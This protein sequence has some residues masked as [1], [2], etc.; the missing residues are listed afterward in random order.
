MQNRFGFK[1]GVLL[2]L[3]LIVGV[4]VVVGMYG[5]DR[6]FSKLQAVDA[7]I[8]ELEGAVASQQQGSSSA[9]VSE[10]RAELNAIRDAIA[11]RPIN[12]NMSGMGVSG[13]PT[14][15]TSTTDAETES[16]T[17][18][19][20]TTAPADS[21]SA[22]K[23]GWARPGVEIAWQEPWSF[24]TNP[25]DIPGFEQGGEFTEIIGAQPPRITPYLSSDVYGRR[26]IDQVMQSLGAYDSET[27]ETRGVLA[28][29]WQFD[30]DGLWLRVHINPDARFSD[31]V[32]VTAEDV[33]YT[34]MDFIK[35]ERIEAERSR[36]TLE[37]IQDVEII[38]EHTVEF[39][40]DKA[41]F[42]N[43][44]YTLGIYVLPKHFYS[45]L[46]ESTINQSTGLIMG[47]GPFRLEIINPDD[48]W[49][50]GED[51]QIVRNER[52]WGA[53]KAPLASMRFKV[54]KE[55]TA[56]LVG[57]RNGDGDML[58]PSSTQYDKLRSDTDFLADNAIYKWV[59]MRSGYSFIGW[60]CGRRGGSADGPW[61]PFH[62]MRV[63]RAMTMTLNREDM[64]RDIWAGVGVVSTGPNSPSSPS[65]NPAITPWPYDLDGARA[66]LKE[67]GWEDADGDGILEYQKDDEYF[68]KGTPFK[69]EFTI[70]NSGETSERIISYLVSQCEEVGITCVPRVVDWSFYSD[71]LKRRDF[72]A[73]IM[74]WSASS[75]ESDPRQIWHR[76]SIQDQG[77]NFI[78]WDSQ[79]ASDLVDKGRTSMDRDERMLVWHDFHSVVHEEQPYTFLR[80]SPWIRMIKRDVGN[81]QTYPA[82]LSPGEFF[83]VPSGN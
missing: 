75:P 51:I 10:L 2:V 33:R 67:A 34:V 78:Q 20:V 48:Q 60:Q 68:S 14:V 74:A 62:D 58:T 42:T 49:S 21:G 29:A 12:I 56:A 18:A 53:E 77:D 71:M 66:L 64:I 81:V 8:G 13:S 11:T 39:T 4:L 36:S 52:Y 45:K 54:I 65:S 61:T 44:D 55:S 79:A 25:R 19:P 70:T 57:Y 9:D 50:P 7:K 27:L 43:L 26:V 63:R 17:D 47:S 59:N 24:A 80:V 82:G 23:D 69:F 73:M 28:D 40:F 31:G 16:G 15:T 3:L 6:V 30:P 22:S 76:S 38:D 32:P 35:N 1:D 72:D 37:M 46:E 41:V 5:N 83:R